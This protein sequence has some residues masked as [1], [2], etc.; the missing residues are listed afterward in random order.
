MRSESI[1]EGTRAG[2]E[3]NCLGTINPWVFVRPLPWKVFTF[4]H[5]STNKFSHEN[6]NPTKER[7]EDPCRFIRSEVRSSFKGENR[8]ADKE[9]RCRRLKNRQ[10]FLTH[11]GSPKRSMSFGG[12]R[13][14]AIYFPFKTKSVRAQLG[15]AQPPK[16]LS[17]NSVSFIISDNSFT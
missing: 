15:Y 12:S 13:R 1:G 4:L 14:I 6:P 2:L 8:L 10:D 16:Y 7:V 5:Q 11:R 9:K 3:P 17:S